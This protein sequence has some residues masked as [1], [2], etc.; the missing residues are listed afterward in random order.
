MRAERRQ[1]T[2]AAVK[3]LY[4]ALSGSGDATRA[5]IPFHLA[6][7]G[8]LE[9][10]HDVGLVLAGDATELLQRGTRESLQGVGLPPMRELFAK[11]REH[12]VPVYV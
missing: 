8:S 6:V 7:N 10:G 4:M 3:I 11:L 9:V 1:P 12:E 5:S 2:I